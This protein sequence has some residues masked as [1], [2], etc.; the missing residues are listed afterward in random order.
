MN[1]F[2]LERKAKMLFPRGNAAPHRRSSHAGKISGSHQ[3]LRLVRFQR[4]GGFGR[5][6]PPGESSFGQPLL[7]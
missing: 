2:F 5:L 6:R 4:L 7:R 1:L 3:Q